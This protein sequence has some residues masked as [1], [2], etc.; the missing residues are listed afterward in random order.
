MSK[1]KS[2][3]SGMLL[4]LLILS[5]ASNPEIL[6]FI[7]GVE[8]IGLELFM[9]LLQWHSRHVWLPAISQ[10]LHQGLRFFEGFSAQA[11]CLPSAASLSRNPSGLGY[12]YHHEAFSFMLA[13]LI[14]CAGMLS[15][16]V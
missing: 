4:L 7:S 9:V 15:A 11:V 1:L 3:V 8:A 2:R 5:F 10:S 6:L 14:I 12:L 16:L 13:L